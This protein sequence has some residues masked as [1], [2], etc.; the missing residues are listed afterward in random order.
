MYGRALVILFFLLTAAADSQSLFPSGLTRFAGL[1]NSAYTGDNG[2]AYYGKLR[3]AAALARDAAGNLYI[4]EAARIRKIDTRGIITTVAPANNPQGIAVDSR[5]NLYFSENQLTIRRLAPDGTLTTVVNAA[6]VAPQ[7]LAI[8]PGDA[9]NARDRLYFTDVRGWRVFL[10]QADGTT[11]IVAGT[12]SAGTGGEGG[13][14]TAADLFNPWQ[15]AFDAAGNLYVADTLR[16][17]KID[18]RGTLTK[19]ADVAA[20]GVAVTARAMSMRPAPAFRRSRRM[21]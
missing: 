1:D 21:A 20:N 4:T 2:P 8:D 5:G 14:A 13:P 6:G 17:L 15:L 19:I 7:G 9:R 18:T 11:A 3:S 12:G 10:L 16:M